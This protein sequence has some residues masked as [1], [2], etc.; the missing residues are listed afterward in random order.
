MKKVF[1]VSADFRYS[2]AVKYDYEESRH[3]WEADCGLDGICRCS[4]ID[5]TKVESVDVGCVAEELYLDKPKNKVTDVENYCVERILRINKVW[6]AS[7][8]EI[9]VGRGY[10]GEEIDSIY[11]CHS[12]IGKINKQ[13]KEM[14]ALKTAKAKI[15]YVL[16][17][18]YGYILDA[19][20]NKRF[21]VVKIKKSNLVFQR[22]HYTHLDS[23]T[24]ADYFEWGLPRGICIK[25]QDEKY[26]LIDGYHRV[27]AVSDDKPFK[28]YLAY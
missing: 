25:E 4:T 15:Y 20:K 5:Y 6:N 14:L 10:Y 3:C 23:D 21:R 28:I 12:L 17:L 27:G 11:L 22:D 8:W 2:G 19:I 24:V 7:N 16:N 1:G 26:R 13:L 18:E 9:G